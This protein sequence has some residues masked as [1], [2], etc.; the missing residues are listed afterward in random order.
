MKF[1]SSKFLAVIHK[2]TPVEKVPF[3]SQLSSTQLQSI[4]LTSARAHLMAL[5]AAQFSQAQDAQ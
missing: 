2:E 4:Q 5:L 1:T 3:P